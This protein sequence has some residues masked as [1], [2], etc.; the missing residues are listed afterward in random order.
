MTRNELEVQSGLK[1][2]SEIKRDSDI[3]YSDITGGIAVKL[4]D[5]INSKLDGRQKAKVLHEII[6]NEGFIEKERNA[7][8]GTVIKVFGT[9]KEND[10]GYSD[11]MNAAKALNKLGYDVYMLPLVAK[12][13]SPDYILGKRNN[14]FL[15]ELKTIYGKNSLDHRLKKAA[16]QADRIILNMV[17]KVDSRYAGDMIK[18]FYLQNPNIKEIKVLLGGK[19]I[20]VD[21]D[22]VSKRNF[23]KTF[24]DKWAR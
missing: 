18:E 21:H 10:S 15:S 12:N 24:M 13:T 20:D 7:E 14:L 1:M 19:Q 8:K 5:A 17:G 2:L 11:N 3:L 9:I 4:A 16:N 22:A 6:R 23:T